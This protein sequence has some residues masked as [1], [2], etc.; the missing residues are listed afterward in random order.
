MNDVLQ[1]VSIN[2]L[3]QRK[4]IML[5]LEYIIFQEIKTELIKINNGF[6]SLIN[7]LGKFSV[8]TLIKVTI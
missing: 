5:T 8:L 6:Y 4:Y 2:L 7:Y 1:I 3:Y